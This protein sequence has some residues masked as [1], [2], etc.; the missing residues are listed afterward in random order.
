MESRKVW[1][2]RT[3]WWESGRRQRKGLRVDF[4]GIWQEGKEEMTSSWESRKGTFKAKALK[5]SEE[6]EAIAVTGT[7]VFSVRLAD[8]SV[9]NSTDLLVFQSSKNF[10]QRKLRKEK[11]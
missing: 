2:L 8:G 9:S 11:K 6:R 5:K 1:T 3:R 4:S 10:L 7:W